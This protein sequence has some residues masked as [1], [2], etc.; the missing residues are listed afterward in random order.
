MIPESGSTN[1][2]QEPSPLK[3]VIAQLRASEESFRLMVESVKDYG[4]FMLSPAGIILSWNAGAERIKGYSA[5]EAIGKHFEIFYT[6]A[7][8]QKKHPQH[9]LEVAIR[10]GKYEEEGWRVRKDGTQF[11]ANVVITHLVSPEGKTLGFGKVTRDLTE[12]KRA[13]E[14]LRDSEEQARHVYETVKDYAILTLSPEGIVRT[15][16]EGARRIKGYEASEIIGKHFSNFYPEDDNAVG[17][18]E[19]ELREATLT[20]RFEDEGW[21]VRKDGTQFWANVV[22]TALYDKN[23]KLRG[24]SK[25]TRDMTER[26]RAEDRLKMANESLERR[27]HIR[28]DELSRANES[29][30][31]EIEQR[32]RTEIE[33][34]EAVC[35]R[36]EF[37]SIASHE[38]RTPVTPLKLQMQG[39]LAHLRRGTL[40]SLTPERLE[41][42][43]TSLDR[44][45]SR[46]GKL[47]DSLLD[48]AR[49][50]AGKIKIHPEELDV[51]EVVRETAARFRREAKDSGSVLTL[52]VPES[53][54]AEF[55]RVRLEQIISNL[56]T[57][58][59]KFGAG[60]PIV[61]SASLGSEKLHLKVLDHGIGIGP[62]DLE[63]IFNR[64]EQVSGGPQGS[65]S[66]G[67]GLGLYIT[68]QIVRA[69]DGEIFVEST[70][71][72]GT[73]FFVELPLGKK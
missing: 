53:G 10:D 46:L 2:D 4:I 3:P 19:Y 50:N 20:G 60:K 69:H 13:E 27:V 23:R 47:M 44:S 28:T 17:K 31:L 9:E 56:I 40:T 52:D 32:T 7:A 39:L 24:F 38:L 73:T 72:E 15:W 25:V 51:A 14:V 68:K 45:L 18:W 29:L 36:D 33:L 48:V 5:K 65:Q 67:L 42:M 55:D 34:K 62:K 30:R 16:N 1:S 35:A 57:N 64:F 21:R 26:K 43:A 12:R 61:V 66:G 11:W 70:L 59:I 6:E 58:A 49:I 54:K 8:R 22:I 63:R 71:N 41:K 37:L